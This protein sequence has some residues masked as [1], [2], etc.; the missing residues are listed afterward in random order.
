MGIYTQALINLA[1]EE[2][3]RIEEE[4]QRLQNSIENIRSTCS[5]LDNQLG[6]QSCTR[7]YIATCQGRLISFFHNIMSISSNHFDYE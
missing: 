4:H 6:C 7:E 5:N 2:F 3:G 1:P